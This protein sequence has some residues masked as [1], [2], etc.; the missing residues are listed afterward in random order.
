METGMQ[1]RE[2]A[3]RILARLRGLVVVAGIVAALAAI[4]APTASASSTGC[5]WYGHGIKYGVSNGSFCGGINGSGTYVNSVNGNFGQTIAGLDVVC[6]P[7]LKVDFYDN[8]GR[9]YAWRGGAQR[10]GCFYGAFNTL[11]SIGVWSNMRAGYARISLLSYGSTVAV[12]Q[13]GIR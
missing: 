9:W 4:A 12:V 13:L 2:H 6:Q 11:P 3:G 5:T 8:W 10:N 7:S 1:R